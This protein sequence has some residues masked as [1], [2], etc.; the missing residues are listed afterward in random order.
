ML[1]FSLHVYCTVIKT[2]GATPYSL[3]YR[4]EAVMLLEV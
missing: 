1:P 4:L 3:V 2:T